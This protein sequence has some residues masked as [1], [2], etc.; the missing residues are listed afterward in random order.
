MMPLNDRQTASSPDGR[1][2]RR[3]PGDLRLACFAV[4]LGF[5]WI[6][7]GC[8]ARYGPVLY[9]NPHLQ[10]V[11]EAQAQRDIDECEVL[12]E[13]YIKDNPGADAAKS[14]VAGGAAGAVIGG[15]TGAVTGSLGRGIGI[16]AAA[17]AASGLV[18]GIVKA[19][20]PSPL[21]KSFVDRC[22]QDRGYEPLG[23]E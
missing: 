11:G 10:S 23:W 13:K 1:I 22:L 8:A 5:L 2:G 19:S 20:R 16:G 4:I 9:P 21:Y 7:A 15:A 18:H 17:G 12:A 14:T 3:Q 6:V